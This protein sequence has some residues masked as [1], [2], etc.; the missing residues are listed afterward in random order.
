ME[1]DPR[2]EKIIGKI[3]K[4][5]R[6]EEGAREIGS[7][8]EADKAAEMV[9]KLL[10]EYNLSLLDISCKEVCGEDR[11]KQGDDIHA[12]WDFNYRLARMLMN[13]LARHNDCRL[14][15]S[16]AKKNFS[17][18]GTEGS[19]NVCRWLYEYLTEAFSKIGRERFRR[20]EEEEKKLRVLHMASPGEYRKFKSKWTDSFLMGCMG[21]LEHQ[22]DSREV[23]EKETGLS[24]YMGQRID[25]WIEREM[26]GIRNA[27][28]QKTP[29]LIGSVYL[30]GEA[31]GKR[32]SLSPQVTDE[33]KD[34]K[35]LKA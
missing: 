20:L 11:I 14:L 16:P 13:L 33:K 18:V 6:L 29:D 19:V 5:L 7:E 3:R 28:K 10:K 31:E 27:R 32:I 25:E 24:L 21:G 15:V 26:P 2:L 1:K 8:G 9:T 4:L 22:L 30:Q 34:Y 35:R 23:N 17:L 12:A